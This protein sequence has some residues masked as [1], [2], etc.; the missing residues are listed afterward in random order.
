MPISVTAELNSPL[1][2]RVGES[3]NKVN[4]ETTGAQVKL[5]KQNGI[6]QDDVQKELEA[7]HAAVDTG[8][9]EGAEDCVKG[10]A[11]AVDGNL[12]A[13]NQATG[14]LIKDSAIPLSGAADAVAK[15]HKHTNQ[16]DVLDKLGTDNDKLTFDG[17]PVGDGLRDVV[18]A[19]DLETMPADLRD[20]GLLLV[21]APQA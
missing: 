8:L 12:A 2:Q 4:L 18:F 13:F 1:Y 6:T 3:L 20:G 14:K 17:K 21:P 19:E 9:G 11:S 15:K 16:A 7:L 10:P 5:T